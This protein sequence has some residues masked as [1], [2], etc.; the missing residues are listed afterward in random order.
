MVVQGGMGAGTYTRKNMSIVLCDNSNP[1][2]GS[3]EIGALKAGAS[4]VLMEVRGWDPA[5]K[6]QIIGKADSRRHHGDSSQHEVGHW[7]GLYHGAHA[8]GTPRK[9]P[10][11]MKWP[12]ITLKKGW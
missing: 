4:E 1:A 11:P 6:K 8:P 7:L 12:D 9:R 2:A 3:L 5:Q 10:G